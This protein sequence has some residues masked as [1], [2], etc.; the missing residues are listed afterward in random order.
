MPLNP[1]REWADLTTVH[2]FYKSILE[3]ALGYPVPVPMALDPSA[4]GPNPD[5]Q[6][7]Q[8]LRQWL[9]LLDLAIGPQM[10]RSALRDAS[11]VHS[12][13]AVLRQ[14]VVAQNGS[15]VARDK[16]DLITTFLFCQ[17]T[18]Q[19][20]RVEEALEFERDLNRILEISAPPQLPE[21]HRQL[22]RQFDFIRREVEDYTE[23][24]R[25]MESGIIARVRDLKASF[26]LSFYHPHVLATL[27]EH[28]SRFGEKFAELFRLATQQI[29]EFAARVEREGGGSMTRVDEDV[30][31]KQLADVEESKL[32]QQ[33]Y[34]G[35]KE[36]FRKVVKYRKAV[37]RRGSGPGAPPLPAAAHARM[38]Q[39]DFRAGNTAIP[40]GPVVGRVDGMEAIAERL[41]TNTA[42][43]SKLRSMEDTIRAFVRGGDSGGNYAIP[44]PKCTLNLVAAEVDCF[45]ND[46]PGEKSF[47][48]DYASAHQR[49]IAIRA[50][51]LSELQDFSARQESA[52]LWKPHADSLAYL[53][54][55]GQQAIE[56][57]GPVLGIAK[58]RGLDHKITAMNGSIQKLRED[59]QCAVRTLQALPQKSES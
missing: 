7:L 22:A 28:N 18:A 35:A 16:T 39:P 56:H 49:L 30:T 31:V 26:G 46:Y 36:G 9:G 13:E 5:P 44:L 55:A 34:E 53:I 29:K 48:S 50:R 8:T 20:H 21:E 3:Q 43:E 52:Y 47:R 25:L 38:G 17:R 1:V 14:Y 33:E 11:G 54:T 41:V 23:F 27:A 4:Q 12:A 6:V 51:I 24:D 45:R 59:L 10:I 40:P 57:A 2:E 58:Q 15:S 42:E 32:L 37:E 19:G